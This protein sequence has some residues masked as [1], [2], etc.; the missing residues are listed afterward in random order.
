MKTISF[1]PFRYTQQ[2]II[3]F[4]KLGIF[5]CFWEKR[6]AFDKVQPSLRRL[7]IAPGAL[8]YNILTDKDIKFLPLIFP[9]K[10]G[11]GLPVSEY[12]IAACSAGCVTRYSSFLYTHFFFHPS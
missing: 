4:C 10:S 3:Y 11:Y 6:Y 9:K 7:R 1:C 8:V 12:Y 5:L 2:V